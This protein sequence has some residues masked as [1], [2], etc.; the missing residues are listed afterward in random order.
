MVEGTTCNPTGSDVGSWCW[1]AAFGF[2]GKGVGA[3]WKPVLRAWVGQVSG[4][5]DSGLGSV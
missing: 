3:R 2:E 4:I 5:G 1:G